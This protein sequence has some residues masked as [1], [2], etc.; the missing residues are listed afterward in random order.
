MKI[1]QL[2]IVVLITIF[3]C[4]NW[5]KETSKKRNLNLKVRHLNYESNWV[6]I[7]L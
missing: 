2:N 7:S 5:L 6:S 1:I 4:Y 3:L